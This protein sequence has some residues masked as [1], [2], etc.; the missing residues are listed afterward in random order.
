MVDA[1]RRNVHRPAG[2]A[3]A[4]AWLPL[5]YDT[6]ILGITVQRAYADDKHPTVGRITRILLEEGV[7]YYRC[8]AACHS[9]QASGS[10]S[11]IVVIV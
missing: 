5:L 3:A 11:L 10:D 2:I 4:S 6:I 9:G 7:S 8:V 1:E